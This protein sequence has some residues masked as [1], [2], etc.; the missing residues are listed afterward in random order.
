ME[1]RHDGLFNTAHG[2]FQRT[3]GASPVFSAVAR[4]RTIALQ[5]IRSPRLAHAHAAIIPTIGNAVWLCKDTYNRRD[6]CTSPIRQVPSS[7]AALPACFENGASEN[8]VAFGP[9][10]PCPLKKINISSNSE[11]NPQPPYN[12]PATKMPINALVKKCNS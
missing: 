1:F 5:N 7:A 3:A 6:Q 4:L 2:K 10:R 12:V 11:Y 8:A 9:M